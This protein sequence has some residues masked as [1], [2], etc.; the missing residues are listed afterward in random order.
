MLSYSH[1]PGHYTILH[2]CCSCNPYI[3]ATINT[4]GESHSIQNLKI[5]NLC[6]HFLFDSSVDPALLA[7]VD[8]AD[9]EDTSF[10][11]VH[12]KDTSL[13]RVPVC[14]TTMTNAADNLDTESD[15]TPLTPTRPMTIQAKHLYTALEATY[16]FTVPLV[17]HHNILQMRKTIFLKIKLS[18]MMYNY[19]S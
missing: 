17:N 5:N 8:C 3:I 10:A 15:H 11:G 16:P 19:P 13:A 14:N 4:L 9:D 7:G 12:D 6:G 2:H 1:L 18:Q